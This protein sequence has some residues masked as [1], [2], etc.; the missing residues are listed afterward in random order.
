MTKA[1][2]RNLRWHKI[3]IVKILCGK[4]E[5]LSVDDLGV[6]RTARSRKCAGT[7]RIDG[8]VLLGVGLTSGSHS[9]AG[10]G[11]AVLSPRRDPTVHDCR[12]HCCGCHRDGCV[13]MC[14]EARGGSRMSVEVHCMH[15]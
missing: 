14:K 5:N 15:A 7:C 1:G 6:G 10:V 4:E 2:S 11:P 9:V 13:E 3:K 8:S 12:I